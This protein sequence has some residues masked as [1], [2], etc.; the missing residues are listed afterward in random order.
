MTAYLD[1]IGYALGER[2]ATVEEAA[3]AGLLVSSPEALSSA[4]FRRH[5]TCL[6]ET[7]AYDLAREAVRA[8]GPALREPQAI[9]YAA[10]IPGNA[11]LGR[12]EE[13]SRSRDVKHLMDFPAS[14]L[15]ADFGLDRASVIGLDQQ[16]CTGALGA[17]RLAR[18]LLVG[19]PEVEQV[20]CVTAD[21]FP[22][23]ALYEQ[24]Y[25][26]VSDGGA[27]CVVSRKPSGFRI[28]ATHAMTNGALSLASDDETVGAFFSHAHALIGETLA[29]AGLGA[30]D[31]HWIVPQNT[32][33]SA[34][35]ILARILEFDADRVYQ[36][37]MQEVGHVISGDNLINLSRLDREGRIRS[38]ERLLLLMAG[39]GLNWQCVILEKA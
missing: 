9:V 28:L 37:S 34:W 39:Y 20:L 15:Q 32:H 29:K 31:L 30:R 17:L 10:A 23:G 22:A 11:N 27:A 21:R 33:V 1:G 38:G 25:N 7:T 8:V 12:L 36:G 13:F 3:A 19:E 6:P 26:L 2:S 4:G 35:R 14:H 5:F 16:A 24:A 18:L